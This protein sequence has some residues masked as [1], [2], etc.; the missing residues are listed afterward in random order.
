MSEKQRIKI[1]NT[2]ANVKPP[3]IILDYNGNLI[4]P[5]R[6]V[7]VS[8]EV[9]DEC[10]ENWI[11]QGMAQVKTI[12]SSVQ[13]TPQL[14][15]AAQVVTAG[16]KIAE[17]ASESFDDDE[18]EFDPTTAVEAMPPEHTGPLKPDLRQ[19]QG[20]AKISLGT[21]STETVAANQEGLSPLPGDQPV[22]LGNASAF[23]VK[24]PR[25]QG[26]GRVISGS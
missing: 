21:T 1:L 15:A 17:V 10:L 14:P 16:T 4:R 6:H 20:R 18:F 9:I 5:G 7:N 22:E 3:G 12:D 13:L 2:S 26:V 19:Q 11:N 24:A 25:H 23:T 8:V